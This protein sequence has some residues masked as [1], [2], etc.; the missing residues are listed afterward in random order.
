LRACEDGECG[1]YVNYF[2]HC[3]FDEHYDVYYDKYVGYDY[4][5]DDYGG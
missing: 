4:G 1:Y 2:D 5:R 3:N